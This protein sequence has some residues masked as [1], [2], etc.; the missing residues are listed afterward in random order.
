MW[1]H[2][3]A[4]RLMTLASVAA[5]DCIYCGSGM[6]R[7]PS[8]PFEKGQRRLLVQ[9]SL[10]WRC[11][12][13]SVYRVHQGNVPD[14]PEAEDYFGAI[15]CLKELDLKDISAP[16]KDVRQYLL[17]KKERIYSVHPKVFEDVVG[18]VFKDHGYGVRVTAYE[19]DDGIDV[20][21]N[22]S[23][24]HTIGVQVKRHK[25]ELRIEAEQIRSLAGA[26]LLGG[27]TKGIFITTSSFRS[28]ARKTADRYKAIGLPIELMDAERFLDALGISQLR[29]LELTDEEINSWILSPGAH[30]GTGLTKEFVP[31]DDLTERPVMASSFAKDEILE[32]QSVRV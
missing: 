16:L 14:Y 25:K 22:D 9:V 1:K 3:E 31:G 30:I 19:G 6:L 26:L 29:S 12:W 24:G 17:A 27:H 15:G 11:G 2:A 7:L 20:I 5:R 10:C 13:W 21:L 32:I 4:G 28:G 23:S 8:R 18:S